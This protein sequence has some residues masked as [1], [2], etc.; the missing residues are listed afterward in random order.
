[1]GRDGSVG[2]VSDG[3]VRRNTDAGSNPW[4]AKGLF[5]QSPLSVR[6]LSRCLYILIQWLCLTHDE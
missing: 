2:R 3:K 5:S 4:R 6:T 1:M